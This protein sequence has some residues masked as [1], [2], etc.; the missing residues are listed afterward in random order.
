MKK[1]IAKRLNLM[2]HRHAVRS[3]RRILDLAT[4]LIKVSNEDLK[5]IAGSEEGIVSGLS[6]SLLHARG[7]NITEFNGDYAGAF[8]TVTDDKKYSFNGSSAGENT[9]FEGTN[10]GV[11]AIFNGCGAGKN[12]YFE[13]TNAGSDAHFNGDFAGKQTYF[14]G[15]NSGQ[16]TL[17]EGAEAGMHSNFD[18]IGAGSGAK[19]NDYQGGIGTSFTGMCAGWGSEFNGEFAGDGANF[20][21]NGAGAEATFDG[22]SPWELEPFD[23]EPVV[24]SRKDN[25]FNR[26][27]SLICKEFGYKYDGAVR[28]GS[29]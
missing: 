12:A 27:V 23:R 11:G 24:F 13:G 6:Q 9:S 15:E 16:H 21:G 29:K 28:I 1:S 3:N 10:A 4:K 8:I 5:K 25:K 22:F 19:F 2:V 20:E 18:G 14:S 26:R 17:F 7:E